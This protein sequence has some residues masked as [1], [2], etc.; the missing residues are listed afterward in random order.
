MELS[1]R[2]P[3]RLDDELVATCELARRGGASMRFEQQ[4][5]RPRDDA[6]IA[7]AGVRAAC[8]TASTFRPCAM[9]QDLSL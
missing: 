3:A 5:L 9:P 6:L 1:F 2:M 8:L 4:L 7:T